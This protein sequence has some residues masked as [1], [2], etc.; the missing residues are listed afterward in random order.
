[1]AETFTFQAEIQQLLN[2]LVHSLYTERE[3]FLR[4]LISNA[5]DALNRVQFEMLTQE[6]VVEPEAELA[7]RLVADADNNTLTI[8]DSGIGMNRDEM[9]QNLGTIAQ[10]GAAS[11]LQQMQAQQAE[12]VPTTD[13][14][15][16]FGVGFYSVFMVADRVTV[17]S[18]SFRPDDEAWA[19]TSDGSATYTLEPAEKET[20]GTEVTIYLKED[21]AE[22]LEAYRLRAIVKKHSDFVAFPIYLED[23]V[24]NQ[25]TAIWRMPTS[26]VSDEAYGSFF[27]QLTLDYRD[28]LLRL[29]VAADAPVQFYSLMYVP[30][31]PERGL[32]TVR[33]DHGLKLYARKVL[34][35]E[36]NKDF[37][38][39]YLRFVDGVVDSEDLPLNVARETVQATRLIKR[40]GSSLKGKLL[41]EFERVA[42][43]DPDLYARFWEHYGVFIK[44]GIATEPGDAGR[45]AK[46]LRFHSSLSED[47]AQPTVT[48]EDY[49]ARMKDDQEHIYYILAGDLRSAANSPHLDTFKALDYEVLY[50]A[51]TVDSFM[52]MNLRDF[53]GRE[54]RN[55][56]DASLE[57]PEAAADERPLLED[58]PF[59][60]LSAR[61][62]GALG[63]RVL[64][65]RASHT[66]RDNPVRL[67]APEGQ[68]D[69]H[70]QRI[71]RMLEQD[72]EI[73]QRILEVNRHHPLVHNLASWIAADPDAP[74]VGQVIEQ[75]Y[76]SALLL[77]GLHPNPADMV[78]RIQAFMEMAT[79]RP[80]E[81]TD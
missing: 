6:N 62:A 24:A 51:D 63:E 39:N 41:G 2:I 17:T 3:I 57:L 65:V 77:D 60:A 55:V 7:V 66:L 18:R 5:S 30:E 50:L 76:E 70:M 46:L 32:F 69:H 9:I 72:Y 81:S 11:F 35:Q 10:S 74:I 43:E 37:L 80:D 16:Q 71:S 1:M 59:E 25:Q 61:F 4:E 19:W 8:S 67:V 21:A 79:Q 27:Q 73:P 33:Q 14:I 36:Y 29:H 38:P 28:P 45:L 64:E 42:D 47:A 34:I 23:E 31:S 68:L 44:E 53:D 56:D 75:L 48:L 40:I 54:L 49:I 13:V 78:A 22:F 20:R 58:E 52:L 26:E 12:G 15:G